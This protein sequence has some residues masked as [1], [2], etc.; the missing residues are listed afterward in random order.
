MKIY[1]YQNIILGLLL[2]TAISCSKSLDV[3]P[4][5]KIPG[6]A[7]LSDPNG[8]TAF[9][10]NLYYQ[11]PIEDFVYFPRE[12]FNA[13][14]NTGSL[15]LSQYSLEAIHSEWGNWNEFRNEWWDKGYKLNRNI[16][17]LAE[18]IPGLAMAEAEKK[19]LLGEASFLRAYTYFAL[20]KRYGGV[21]IITKNQ[22]YTT[23]FESLSVPRS[24]EKE[25]WDF[26]LA[27][28]DKAIQNLPETRSSVSTTKRRA[29]KWAAYALKSR[30]ALH[31]ASI[32]KFWNLAPLSGPAATLKMVGID[33]GEANRYY[34]Q[35]IKASE[36]IMN[37]GAFSL[38][39]FNPA[40]PQEAAKNYQDMFMDPNIASSEVIFMKGYG[41][42]G[43]ALAHDYDGWNNPNQ[44]SEGFPYRGRTN[45]IMELVDLYETYDKPG[46]I[47]SLATTAAGGATPNEGYNP[48]A[49]YLHF[50]SP[51]QIFQGR[52]ARF[53]ATIIYPNATWK[54]TKIVIQGGI[55]KPDGTLIDSRASF[56]YNGVKY[57][58]YGKEFS[59]QYSGFDGSAN[60]TRTGFLMRKF[61]NESARISSFMQSTT[62]FMDMRYAEILLNYAEAVVESNYT[63]NNA[64]AN[65]A[66]AINNIR[67]RAGHTIDVPL[68]LKNVLRERTVELAFENQNYWDMIRR[69]TF[70]TAFNNKQKTALVPMIDLRGVTPKY[71]FVRKNVPGSNP[72]TF[73]ERSYYL[74]IPGT[75]NNGMV[76]NPQ[77]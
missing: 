13:R 47:T 48:S 50:D 65:A 56:D 30:V 23:D 5:N 29:T 72:Q 44:T 68:S 34:E 10:A 70:H 43:G 41:Q 75:N 54:G 15:S 11:A 67:R 24:T 9:V 52:D 61:L 66:K 46:E 73:P 53:F 25:T 38:Y 60:M 18:S 42:A 33:A 22:D 20:A 28:C 45:P 64:P 3:I 4:K 63:Q 57:F 76:Q 6:D 26:I 49:N 74:P 62:D 55:V 12:G 31:A 59:E 35:S 19:Q 27:E 40:N 58:T 36:A 17:I 77:Y 16:N 32:A 69:R 7:V 37:S 8:I 2:F 51:E 71:I 21:A 14:G 1:K 39:K